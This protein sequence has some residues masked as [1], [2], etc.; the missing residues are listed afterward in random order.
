MSNGQHCT[1][2]KFVGDNFLNE[3]IMLDI[4]VGGG[5][6]YEDNLAILQESPADAE[7]LF[8]SH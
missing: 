7:E 6:V 2:I 1:L 5:L 4:D 8:F 3:F